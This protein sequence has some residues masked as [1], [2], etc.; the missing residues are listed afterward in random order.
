MKTE[1]TLLNGNDVAE[2]RE[3]VAGIERDPAKAQ[4]RPELTAT[5]TGGDRSRVSIKGNSMD[6]NGPGRLGP[7]QLVLAAIASCQID[8]I[9][10]HAT[11]MGVTVEELSVD[12]R[13]E[14]DVRSYLGISGAPPPGYES[15]SL[16]ARLRAPSITEDQLATLAR[17]AES[18]SPVGSTLSRSVQFRARIERL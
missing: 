3:Y 12:V 5:W 16:T 18:A 17:V 7:M 1:P 6:V 13:G 10:T 14:F 4:R 8:V 9:A 15:I 11:L 2:L